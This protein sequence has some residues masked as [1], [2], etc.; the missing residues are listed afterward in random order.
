[1]KVFA[2]VEVEGEGEDGR[3][4]ETSGVVSEVMMYARL[5]S[6]TRCS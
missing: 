2:V 3:G 4:D 6:A 5:A 1:M